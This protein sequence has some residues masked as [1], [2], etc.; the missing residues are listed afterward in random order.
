MNLN[1]DNCNKEQLEFI[2]SDL[3]DCCLIGIPGGGKTTTIIKKILY[4]INNE[5]FSSK[6]F[7]IITFSKK[8]CH[9]FI[10]RGENIVKD[11]FTKNNVKTLHS[12]AGTIINKLDKS[13]SDSIEIVICKALNYI[14]QYSDEDLKKIKCLRNLKLIIIDEAQDISELQ[15]NL[16]KNIAEKM[17][18]NLI[19]VGDPNQN[20][21]QFQNGTDKFLL[22]HS[23]NKFYL[24][25]N[26]RSTPEIINLVNSLKPWKN[27]IPDIIPTKESNG[28][29]PIIY[30]SSIKSI[31]EHM[32]ETIDDY[33][34]E[35]IDLKDISI[36]GPVKKSKENQYGKYNNIGLQYFVN[37]FEEN[38]IPYVKHYT[39]T[40]SDCEI[41]NTK[42]YPKEGH[43]NLYTIHGSKGLEFKKV[44]LLNF[45]TNTYGRNPTSRDYNNFRYLW[46]VGLSRACD[47]MIIYCDYNKNV[48]Y[49]L[50]KC[51]PNLYKFMG[52]QIKF[53]E[54]T[55]EKSTKRSSSI[56]EL[57]KT[58][59]I[60]T[61]EFMLEL[62]ELLDFEITK[63]NIFDEEFNSQEL[64]IDDFEE[65]SSLYGKY[66]EQ[67]FEYY[68]CMKNKKVYMLTELTK[69]FINNRILISNKFKPYLPGF[70]SKVK[71][72]PMQ[73]LEL[74]FINEIK[75]D[76]DEKE[77]EIY[78]EICLKVKEKKLETFSI[79]IPNEL[80]YD[81]PEE[82]LNIVY[83]IDTKTNTNYNLYLLILYF[84]QYE[85][86]AKYLW[87]Q[88]DSIHEKIKSAD[89]IVNNIMKYVNNLENTDLEFQIP[90]VSK[91][92]SDFSGIMDSYD[93][94]NNQILEFK[95]V[96]NVS[97]IHHL[98][99]FFYNLIKNNR[100]DKLENMY[101][102][103]FYE[104]FKFK[105]NI[106][107]KDKINTFDILLK[108]SKILNTKI[109]NLVIMYDLETTGLIDEEKNLYPE[110]ID[111]YFYEINLNC[112]I[113]EG[114][115]KTTN[116]LPEIIIKLTNINDEMLNK[117]GIKQED[118][119]SKFIELNNNFEEPT[120]M[121]HNG[122]HFDHKIMC[123]YKLLS[124]DKVKFL[125]T[126]QIIINFT[127][128]HDKEVKGKLTEMYKVIMNKEPIVAHRAEADVKLVIDILNKLD[129]KNKM[130]L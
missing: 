111:R 48:W 77:K 94:Q 126:R 38:K 69:Q 123:Y 90:L 14:N 8:A 107:N 113:D 81:N 110:I 109:R 23:K 89:V 61:E 75:N 37:Y 31:L 41:V 95:F 24:K 104:G 9:D 115:V 116:K 1:L 78:E 96:K 119:F 27:I 3:S 98:Q 97:L 129:I 17:K 7:L 42:A 34:K 53:I 47:D 45:H 73:I 44:F 5:T 70:L 66:I 30:S 112:V 50:A 63:E 26:Y 125:D 20:I 60:F 55:F 127:K 10:N 105:I 22:E 39:E 128:N 56:T 43:I 106:S 80:V 117:E 103:N 130:K 92:I 88:K 49:E 29:K 100:I 122:N 72:T 52:K 51:N 87:K 25:Q 65:Y 16:A 28:K 11:I 2:K 83:N 4:H 36:I 124:Y 13:K 18:C 62:K 71:K 76:F 33:K 108:L 79:Y 74:D 21:Y 99:V 40:T 54:P 82:I 114:L 102:I 57:L 19:L 64:N 101:I 91:Y 84:Y 12:L 85:H 15:Y 86:E 6:S 120:Y 118:F 35:G 59:E 121:A 58:K 46:Y 93:K 67:I 68:Y 32:I